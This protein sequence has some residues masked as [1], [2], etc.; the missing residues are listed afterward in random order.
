MSWIVKKRNVF[1]KKNKFDEFIL[2]STPKCGG[3]SLEN[4]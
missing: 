1:F 2:I 4:I 3:M